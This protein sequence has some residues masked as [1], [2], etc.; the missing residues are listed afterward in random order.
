MINKWFNA[1][2][3]KVSGNRNPK[4]NQNTQRFGEFEQLEE[5]RCLAFL[6][7]FDGITLELRQ[8]ADDGDALVENSTGVWTVTDNA[9]TFTFDA[10]ENIVVNMLPDTANRLSVGVELEH[11]GN[12][13][14]L[15][16]DGVREALMVGQLNEIGGNLVVQAGAGIQE[17]GLAG[18]E[19]APA[20]PLIVRGDVDI[21]LGQGLDIVQSNAALVTIDGDLSMSGVN[22]FEYQLQ[23]GVVG[24][25]TGGNWSMDNSFEDQP[26][27]L[28]PGNATIEGDFSYEGGI[29]IDRVDLGGSTIEGGVSVN[30]GLGNPFFGDPQLFE[31]TGTVNTGDMMITAGDSNL[32]NEI[33]L[34]GGFNGNIVSY[35]GGNLVDTVD[36]SLNSGDP[37]NAD[38]FFVMGEGADEFLLNQPANLLEI[39]FGNDVGDVFE[40]NVGVIDFEY[41]I[42]N[43]HNFDFFYTALDD[44]LVANQLID[45]GSVVVDNDGGVTG[46]DWRIS[47]NLGGVASL[48]PAENFILN[49]VSDTGNNV[50]MDLKNPVI[51]SIEINLGDGDR[52]VDFTGTANN[53]LRDISVTAGAGNQ[54]VDIS[55]NSPLGVASLDVNL[56]SGFDIVEDSANTLI[57]DEDLRLTGVN[58]FVHDGVL[59]VAR[60]VVVDTR[61]EVEDSEF[62]S[63]GSLLVGATF[64]Y[65]GGGGQDVVNLNGTGT[66]GTEIQGAT[67]IELGNSLD[68]LPQSVNL[69]G[70][71]VEFGSSLTLL[72]MNESSTDFIKTGEGTVY[73]GDVMVSLGNGG[74]FAE[75]FGTFNGTNVSYTGG[76]NVDQLLYGMTGTPANLN[77]Q[78]GAG[79]D[80]FGILPGAAIASPLNVDFGGGMDVFVNDYGVFDFDANLLNL[81]GFD[82]HYTLAVGTLQSVQV[83][84]TGDVSIDNAGLLESIR[85]NG[86]TVLM[87]VSNLIVDM[88]GGT[89]SELSI[90]L[91]TPLA[92][93]LTVDLDDG[94]RVFNMTGSD[95]NV[96]GNFNLLG[97]TASQTANLAVNAPLTVG[98]AAQINL[99]LDADVV[100]ENLRDVMIG[101]NLQMSGVNELLND[102][103]LT[104][105]GSFT[106]DVSFE[107]VA[108][109][110]SDNSPLT[111]GGDFT[112]TGSDADDTI[113]FNPTTTITGDIQIDAAGGTNAA[114]L[115]NV[116]AGSL[117]SYTGGGG[118]DDVVFGGTGSSPVLNV[119]TGEGADTFSLQA[120]ASLSGP[121]TV[122]MGL[123]DD[124]FS[125]DFGAFNFNASILGAEGFNHE[126]DFAQD[127]L[128]STH[129]ELFSNT[130]VT[131]AAG[132][133]VS[134]ES[135]GST[136]PSTLMPVSAFEIS[137]VDNT[138]TDL[139]INLAA[140]VLTGDLVANL[141]DGQ[142]TLS[143][144]VP[145]AA[146][147]VGGSLIISGGAGQQTVELSATELMTING[148]LNIDLGLDNDSLFLSGA[149]VVV[150][151][152]MTPTGVNNYSL[153]GD[154]QVGMN[155]DMDNSADNISSFFSNLQVLEVGGDF[156]YLG[157]SMGDAVFVDNANIGGDIDLQLGDGDNA[158]QLLGG[159]LGGTSVNYQSG[160]GVDFFR[161]TKS[162]N[163]VDLNVVMGAADDTFWLDAGA[164]INTLFVDFG[165]GDNTFINDYGP[166][167]FPA[168]LLSLGSFNHT[169][170]PVAGTLV[171]QQVSSVGST[172]VF[173]N[174]GNGGAIRVTTGG[175]AEL[176]AVTDL[177]ISMLD[178][179]GDDL[180]VD[181]DSELAGNLVVDLGSGGRVLNLTGI[182]NQ[183]GGD[184]DVTAGGF[185]QTLNAAVNDELTVAG[186]ASI[187]LG[188]GV[189]LM[190]VNA[191]GASFENG[192][193]LTNVNVLSNNNSLSVVGDL[194]IDVSGETQITQI[195]DAAILGVTGDLNYSGSNSTD[196]LTLNANSSIG[197][198]INVN[199]G[200]GSNQAD[201]LG[202]LGGTSVKYT[203]GDGTDN[204]TF[205]T[206]GTPADVN[207]KLKS[208]DD[209]FVLEAGAAV[210]TDSLRVDFGGGDDTFTS[211]YGQ[212]D[213]NA[214]L[215]DLDGYNAFFD[216]TSGN[217]DINQVSDSGDV[218]LDNNGTN[219]EVRYG[220]GTFN[221]ITP[222]NDIRLVLLD[223]TSTNVVT[224]FA[225]TRVG[226]TIIQLRSGDRNVS[227]TGTDN[228]YTGL[229]RV[230]AS[231]GV[232]TLD[233]SVNAPLDVAGT[234]IFNGR[235]GSDVL[236]ATNSVSVSEAMLLRGVNQ[237]VNNAGLV[238]DGDFNQITLQEDED[239]RLI[240][241]ASFNVGGNL[242]YLGGGG[243]DAISFK[244]TGATIGGF[245]YVDIAEA[246]DASNKQRIVLTGGFNTTRLVVDG[247]TA[248]AGNVFQTDDATS[249]IDDVIVNFASSSPNNTASF[250]GAYGGTYG[251]YR[252]GSGSDYVTF[253]AT[254]TDMLFASLM[255]DGDDVFTI[256]PTAEPDFLYV[257]FGP[258][259]DTLINE[260]GE[261]LPFGNNI[262][263][264]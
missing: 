10:A 124:T 4:R 21:Q 218:V 56:G 154:L 22:D 245:T 43:F 104:I 23:V 173:D 229:L 114:Q 78:L 171:S 74:N 250:F 115:T 130:V 33:N 121:L 237:F 105:G 233:V 204:V 76:E 81:N 143:L 20:A 35:N 41:D 147:D 111:I 48:S 11:S 160:D 61:V 123:G 254:A 196:V 70:P 67:L 69:D 112:Y 118:V 51:A 132:D 241:N 102:A 214:R 216:L 176:G 50:E 44:R 192:L 232:Q 198:N 113:S 146:V 108:T 128:T 117:V 256:A 9:D 183:I 72:A 93:D 97:G 82:H 100:D 261:P 202:V 107:L 177:D 186:T 90:G 234:F 184:L 12:V 116:N 219:E 139:E 240:S 31:M 145:A 208:G 163:P 180:S 152:G 235:D 88:L 221:T 226:N 191:N 158:V 66:L 252:G 249:V 37:A 255:G 89:G 138:S 189:D 40:N 259:N 141:G 94:A 134:F 2:R 45:T 153:N 84:D 126:Y 103:A 224:D 142:R 188:F 220:T 167:D 212:F 46:V 65:L 59:A 166:L 135:T 242:T 25:P 262:F 106:F 239:T 36:Y 148:N 86:T 42:T 223:N 19:E 227:F 136:N 197:G 210:A 137:L 28:T 168:T 47:P 222:A 199:A 264:L 16:G 27:I 201:L 174:N 238:V 39:D 87:P 109:T 54:V 181:L 96:N 247:S 75:L 243:V 133:P 195:V 164:T 80:F 190:S 58:Q 53:P 253:G 34:L 175:I 127:K 8:T 3:G 211:N 17:I 217:L 129:V 7:F 122:D 165:A 125:S 38:A 258:G 206:T 52:Q 1:K 91:E 187:N 71:A 32:G 246:T 131:F 194:N 257:D 149:G 228:T 263:N 225:N 193:D 144:P 207:V 6:G 260:I 215:L 151:G 63:N 5:K 251:T 14:L 119:S 231:D 213:F 182:D 62:T 150:V 170:D 30:L 95:N 85:F 83:S 92:G 156:N 230:E 79:D 169:Y 68:G 55:V 179:S 236:M 120:G 157:N 172:V 244:S 101:G 26:S 99:G 73:G 140:G 77:V 15:L 60:D 98:L 13:E 209:V 110:L 248:V 159:S 49:M 185:G 205:G 161:Y 162:G 155:L 24:A 57:I 64:S 200:N 29:N 178:L 203:G 18:L